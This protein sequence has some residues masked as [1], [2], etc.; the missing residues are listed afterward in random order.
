MVTKRIIN[1]NLIKNRLYN[2]VIMIIILLL[3][4]FCPNTFAGQLD[5]FNGKYKIKVTMRGADNEESSCKYWNLNIK[6]IR[7]FFDNAKIISD[8]EMLNEYDMFPCYYKGIIYN[9]TKKYKWKIRVGGICELTTP[10]GKIIYLGCKK[11]CDS[12]F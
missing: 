5:I 3:Y 2:T 4:M 10:E 9:K 1:N 12:I 6:K 7:F 11:K 8:N